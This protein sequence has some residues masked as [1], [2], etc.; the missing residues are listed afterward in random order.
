MI[1]FSELQQFKN[2]CPFYGI[3]FP[4]EGHKFFLG[5]ALFPYLWSTQYTGISLEGKSAVLIVSGSRQHFVELQWLFEDTIIFLT[6]V[7]RSKKILLR[8]KNRLLNLR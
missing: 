1:I 3:L 4:P 2:S 6:R 5:P 8:A 7:K